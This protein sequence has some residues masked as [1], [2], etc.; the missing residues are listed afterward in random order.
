ME[1]GLANSD[2]KPVPFEL[3]SGYALAVSYD[4][5][6]NPIVKVKTFGRADFAKV[7]S[8]VEQMF[9]NVQ[10]FQLN[11]TAP[12]RTDKRTGRRSKRISRSEVLSPRISISE[13]RSK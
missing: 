6:N 9:P 12:A 2:S 4:E 7:R 13:T 10:I 3:G 5:N 1:L 8:E 11:S